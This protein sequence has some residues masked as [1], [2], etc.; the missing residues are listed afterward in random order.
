MYSYNIS[1]D[2]NAV[3]FRDACMLIGENVQGI[4]ETYC[5]ED[6]DGTQ[7]QVYKTSNGEITIFNDYEVG[8]VY[9]NSEFNLDSVVLPLWKRSGHES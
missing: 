8:A 3:A 5:L 1:K 4:C 7:I 6:V 2:V 9:A